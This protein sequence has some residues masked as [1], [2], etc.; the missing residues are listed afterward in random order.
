[1]DCPNCKLV[2]PPTATRCDCGYDFETYTVQEPYLTVR[3]KQL[4]RHS[5]GL[6]GAILGILVLL[7]LILRLTSA[8]SAFQQRNDFKVFSHC[9]TSN[10]FSGRGVFAPKTKAH[11]K[12][13]L[14]ILHDAAMLWE[15]IPVQRNPMSLIRIEGAD[16]RQKEPIVLTM[17]EFRRLLAEIK[18]EPHRTMV[19]VA[20]CLG[21]RISEVLGLRWQDL[22]WI[23]GEVKIRRGVVNGVTDD[24]KTPASKQQ[25]PFDAAVISALKSWRLQA[26]F[27]AESDYVFASPFALGKKPY[28]GYSPNMRCSDLPQS[29]QDW[30][31]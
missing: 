18:C 20:A 17:A 16:R 8:A 14:H 22:D 23:R 12:N 2:N 9:S 28:H 27:A 11:I 4:S 30:D 1:M 10:A 6:T 19:L 21:L 31:L 15:Y 7:E 25:L 3:D 5:V 24:T 26:S 13:V 29:G